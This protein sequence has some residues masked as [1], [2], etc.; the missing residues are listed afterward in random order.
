MTFVSSLLVTARRRRA[1]AC[2]GV[3]AAMTLSLVAGPA[4]AAWGATRVLYVA[5]T[6]TDSGNACKVAATP[7]ATVG[8]ALA[9]AAS[10]DVIQVAAGRYDEHGLTVRVPVTIEGA[11][12]GATIIDG[13]KMGQVMLIEDGV[14][15][16]VAKLAI[17]NGKNT[18][19]DGGGM[20]NDGTVSLVQDRFAGDHSDDPGGAI[21]N[22]GTIA[23][24]TGDTFS[25]NSTA[26]Y[27]G[28]IENF[29]TIGDATG[30]TFEANFGDFGAGA[31][32][33]QGSIGTLDGSSFTSNTA[34]F[35]GAIDNSETI[36]DLS[37]DT[38]W[39]NK[40]DGY[41]GAIENVLGATITK[42]TDD[43][44]ADN[45]VLDGLGQGGG[46]EQDTSSIGLLADDTIIGNHAVIG[47]GLYNDDS[48]ISSVTG[49]IV[50]TNTGTEGA[51][52]E[53]FQSQI[54][55]GG[56]N[57]ESDSDANRNCGFSAAD[58]D[59]VGHSPGLRQ[60]GAWGGPTLTAPPLP[61]SVAVSDGAPGPCPVST[62]ERGVPR[63]QSASGQCD[64]GAVQWAPPT[65]T[66]LAPSSGPASGGTHVMITGS[67]FTLATRVTYGGV[68][69]QFQ[70]L[71]DGR[72]T[73]TAPPGRGDEL[74]RV[75]T[76]DGRST[77]NLR[78]AYTG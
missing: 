26:R 51:E 29:G 33:N 47:G 66:A 28:A 64:I 72:I 60:L 46:I 44:V 62:D 5:T 30:D 36:G 70:V 42:L 50:A 35:A 74:V 41:A 7:C 43:T 48:T 73:T 23:T 53:N 71:G 20:E 54:T 11:G 27:G 40:V 9:K 65:P 39:H 17:V 67:G 63:P 56:Y 78:F 57:L 2:A 15:A 16:T 8:H 76:P 55:D 3:V 49:V 25:Q 58:H 32:D 21:V 13:Q 34:E 45:T 31:I 4:G 37:G 10:G 77:A 59:V 52:C 14:T 18:G 19:S 6:G 24:L 38:F 22:F 1:A 68:P 75:L 12:P 61:T 69:A